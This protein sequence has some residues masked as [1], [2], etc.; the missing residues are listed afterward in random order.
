MP[1]A[2]IWLESPQSLI[3]ALGGTGH[4]DVR[5]WNIEWHLPDGRIIDIA[6]DPSTNLPLIHD[7]TL[8]SKEKAEHGAQYM[9][10]AAAPCQP[11]SDKPDHYDQ[12]ER[13]KA[14]LCCTSVTDETNQNLAND[15]KELLFNHQKFC[16]NMQDL[17]QLMK[18][19]NARD[20]AGTILL[21]RPPVIP[22]K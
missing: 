11:C 14:V 16:I 5:G 15:Q 10:A 12:Y 4:A 6:I 1:T 19:Q 7:F 22:T 18:P 13:K 3:R 17:Q 21:Q 20:Q 2:D 8:S 9:N